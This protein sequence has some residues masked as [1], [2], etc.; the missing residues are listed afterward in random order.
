MPQHNFDCNKKPREST[1]KS[2]VTVVTKRSSRKS[3][4]RSVTRKINYLHTDRST[5]VTEAAARKSR[6]Q[7][8]DAFWR[9]RPSRSTRSRRLQKIDKRICEKIVGPLV[10]ASR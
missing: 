9:G 6:R 1:A 4:L 7:R 10:A 3:Q 2:T 5:I 8:S